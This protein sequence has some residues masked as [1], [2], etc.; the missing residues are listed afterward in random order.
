MN[1]EIFNKIVG[2]QSLG[3]A[4]KD[5]DGD[6]V[7]NILDCQPNNPKKQGWVHDKVESLKQSYK[8]HKEQK[9]V[10]TTKRNE[11]AKEER[12]KQ[13]EITGKYEAQQRAAAER[14]RIAAR[15]SPRPSGGGVMGGLQSFSKG[16]G[17]LSGSSS[18]PSTTTTSPRRKITTYV[19]KKGGK[20][21]IKK[22]KYVGGGVRK[23]VGGGGNVSNNSQQFGDILGSSNGEKKRSVFTD[24]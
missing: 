2:K 5:S 16:V 7:A 23:T 15:Y 12:V 18:R 3:N 17:I 14:K 19:K 9:Y 24:R 1:Q 8:E 6:G 13:A 21:Y 20:G 10:E 22:T 11:A 4:A